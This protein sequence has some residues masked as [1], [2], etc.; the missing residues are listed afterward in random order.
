MMHKK[1]IGLTGGIGSG[2]SQVS[3]ILKELGAS[4]IDTD[5]VYHDLLL[6][7]KELICRLGEAFGSEVIENGTLNRKKLAPI[8]YHNK[9]KMALLNQI[10]HPVIYE[11]IVRRIACY[12]ED[13]LTKLIVLDSPLLINTHLAPL[14]EEIWYVVVDLDTRIKRII[15]RDGSSYEEVL[16]KMKSQ[17]SDEENIPFAD[18]VI[19]NNGTVHELK[20]YVEELWRNTLE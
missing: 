3:K 16:N 2:K 17:R 5:A 1:V 6:T 15:K 8:V 9:E 12:Q 11:E 13:P 20:K 18:K 19:Y 4:I 14:A 10:T 7:D